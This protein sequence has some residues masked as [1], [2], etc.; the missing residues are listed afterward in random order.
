VAE[1]GKFQ[2]EGTAFI[3]SIDTLAYQL[4]PVRMKHRDKGA[5]YSIYG[6]D[7]GELGAAWRRTGEYG[8]YLSVK[9][10][11]PS[12][13]APINAIMR[14]TPDDEGFYALR[15]QRRTENGRGKANNGNS[16]SRQ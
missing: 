14:L 10:D 9:L 8:D 2:K 7:D 13:P 4:N 5:D 6:P 3:G 1:I 11:C 16:D 12:L 15:W